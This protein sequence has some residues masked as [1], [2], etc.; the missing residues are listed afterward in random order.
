MSVIYDTYTTNTQAELVKRSV[1]LRD[2]INH[3]Q[4]FLSATFFDSSLLSR[5]KVSSQKTLALL[6]QLALLKQSDSKTLFSII[7]ID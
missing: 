1:G 3:F 7:S 4:F 2:K 6:L 5:K